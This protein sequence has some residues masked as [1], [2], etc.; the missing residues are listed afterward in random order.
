MPRRKQ[1]KM[2]RKWMTGVQLGYPWIGSEGI[3]VKVFVNWE[4]NESRHEWILGCRVLGR[5]KLGKKSPKLCML[6]SQLLINVTG[7]KKRWL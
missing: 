1:N 4:Q 3:Y 5:G 7:G 6:E 2:T